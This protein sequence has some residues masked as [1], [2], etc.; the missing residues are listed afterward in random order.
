MGLHPKPLSARHAATMVSLQQSV[1]KLQ[2][3]T[4]GI[5]SGFPLATLP[6]VIDHGYSGSGNP[7]VYV[8]GA[9]E[10]SGP[11]SFL[12]TYTP[13]AG[14]AVFLQPVGAQ[15]AYVITGSV[16]PPAPPPPGASTAWQTVTMENGFTGTIQYRFPDSAGIN[17]QLSGAVTLPGGSSVYN[18]VQWGL[19]SSAYCPSATR[20]WLVC[21]LSGTSYGNPTYPGAPHGFVLTNGALYLYGVPGSLN[22]D[23]VDVSGIYAL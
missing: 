9:G 20:N 2:S 12:G 21:P 15:Q 7:K 18:D 22:G 4:S 10:L 11:Y 8:N 6:G 1:A 5:D 17:V 14:Q 16:T 13:V 23:Q 3:R 19:V